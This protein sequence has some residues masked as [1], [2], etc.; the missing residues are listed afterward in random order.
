MNPITLKDKW[1]LDSAPLSFKTLG[2]KMMKRNI[3]I[4]VVVWSLASVFR[5]PPL[6]R[7]VEIFLVFLN[8]RTY[9]APRLK[10]KLPLPIVGK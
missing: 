10:M 4:E 6:W 3:F 8:R 9:G 1:H 7:F 5:D 2:R